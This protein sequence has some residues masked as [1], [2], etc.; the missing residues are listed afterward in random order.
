MAKVHLI[1]SISAAIDN[2]VDACSLTIN[3][4]TVGNTLILAYAIRSNDDNAITL[5][6]G[7]NILGGGNNADTTEDIDQVIYFASKKVEAT[8]E[9][10]TISQTAAKRI[11]AICAE[12]AN[13]LEVRMRNDLSA[14]G[15]TKYSVVGAK[16]GVTD[17]ML[18]GVTSSYY[19]SGNQ[20][21]ATP[22]DLTKLY[23]DTTAE[24]LACWF[25]NGEAALEHTFTTYPSDDDRVA[26]LECL[27]LIPST[28]IRGNTV[29]V[30]NPQPD[31][32]Q[33][34]PSKADYIKNK[35][36]TMSLPAYT[37]DDYGKVLSPSADGL[38]WVEQTGGGSLP[39]NAS[40][41]YYGTAYRCL[42]SNP[43]ISGTY[44][45]VT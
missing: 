32:T 44:E 34:D 26:V 40:L 30:S 36:G 14:I 10:V 8:S 1:K 15:T 9:E 23:G 41:T 25:D 35:P 21:T 17:C 2:G 7:W 43:V 42:N 38:V 27:Q 20:Q 33:T 24:R 22:D 28:C 19:G 31:W 4:C 12:F 3:D 13:V 45:E 29:G 18:Y 11:Y 5:S 39:S 6:D 37:E 16:E